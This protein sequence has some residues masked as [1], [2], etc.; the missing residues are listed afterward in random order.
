MPEMN[1]Y[2]LV[3]LLALG[4]VYWVVDQVKEPV[5]AAIVKVE[6]G[7]QKVGR[8]FKHVVTLGKK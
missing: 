5:K 3:A 1:P 4:G 7:A 6:H 8:G 2:L